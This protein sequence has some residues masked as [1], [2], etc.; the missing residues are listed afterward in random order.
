MRTEARA[1]APSRD[2]SLPSTPVLLS[3]S[4]GDADVPWGYALDFAQALASDDVVFALIKGGDHRLS[5]AADVARL[6]AAMEELA[7][8]SGSSPS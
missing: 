6:I 5:R 3:P 1:Q 2:G 7:Q 4:P 8:T